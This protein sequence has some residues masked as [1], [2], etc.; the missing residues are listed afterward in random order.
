MPPAYAGGADFD[1]AGVSTL[2]F[3]KIKP[4][5]RRRQLELLT[6]GNRKPMAN[7]AICAI[8]EEW[9]DLRDMRDLMGLERLERSIFA[10][11]G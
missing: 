9:N 2:E 4:D 8:C 11:L 10:S 5:I 6:K 7:G 3:S 1:F